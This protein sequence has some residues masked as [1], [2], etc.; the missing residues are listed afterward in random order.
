MRNIAYLALDVH[1]NNSVLGEMDDSGKFIVQEFPFF[2]QDRQD[3]QD[4]K[5]IGCRA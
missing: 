3:V 5:S 1:A 4:I 2:G